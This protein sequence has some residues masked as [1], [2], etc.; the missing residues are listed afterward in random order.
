MKTIEINTAQ[1]VTIQYELASLGNRFFAYFIDALV[2]AG[3]LTFLS[4]LGQSAIQ[5]WDN[6]L[7]FIYLI[8]FPIFS[9]YTLFSEIVMHGQ[10]I[11]KKSMG[12]K[13]VK[14]S[15][16]APTTHDY[17]MRWMFRF[18]DLWMSLGSVGSLLINAS[19]KSQRLGGLLSGTTVIRT[20]SQRTFTLNDI[21][22][23][24]TLDTYDPSYPQIRKFNEQD[25]L[26]IKKV[27]ERER[28]YPNPAHK[29]AV[30]T[31]S[32]HVA[33][34]LD[35]TKI[36]KDQSKFLRTLINDYIVLTR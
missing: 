20:A 8:L 4:I 19:P 26:F 32:L 13:V 35:I 9:F 1:K 3:I 24:S 16:D 28:R 23:I 6:M 15:G 22:K 5:N 33:E 10:T 36:P 17:V 11:G 7:V 31:L 21:L 14:L 30:R 2:L 25:M 12:L 29:K 27:L 34:R 18:V